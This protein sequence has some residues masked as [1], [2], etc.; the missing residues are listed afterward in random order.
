M[1]E[2]DGSRQ[3]EVSKSKKVALVT[4][5]SRGIGRAISLAFAEA[6]YPVAINYVRD[7]ASARE[8]LQ[9]LERFRVPARIFQ[10]NTGVLEEVKAL[11]SSIKEQ[12]GPVAILVNNAGINRD[13]MFGLSK[14]ADWEALIRTNLMGTV[15]CAQ[16]ALLPMMK[17]WWGRIINLS[18]ISS[19][20]GGPGRTIYGS[21][22]GAVEAFTRALASEVGP[23][24][25]TVNTVVAG[26]IETE[27]TR[28]LIGKFGDEILKRTP[29]RRFGTPSDVAQLV[30]FLASDAASY[31]T[32]TT[33]FIDGGLHIS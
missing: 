17:Q 7:E 15:H 10:A 30:L 12:L 13:R 14:P 33:I 2:Q 6:G 32:G 29:L 25:I 31:I 9:M 18:S 26:I 21:T 20:L 23:R 5:G 19:R 8:T 1:S 11:F 24:Q 28:E 27:M 4:G 16:Q 22:K 3:D